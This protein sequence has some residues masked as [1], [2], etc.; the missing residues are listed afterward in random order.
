[1]EIRT[2]STMDDAAQKTRGPLSPCESEISVGCERGAPAASPMDLTEDESEAAPRSPSALDDE[3]TCLSEDEYFRPL[4]R[5][6]MSDAS[7]PPPPPSAATGAG[8]HASDSLSS[9]EPSSLAHRPPS[10]G[11]KQPQSPKAE[12]GDGDGDGDVDGDG[13]ADNESGRRA[14]DD[15]QGL[16][17]DQKLSGLRSFSILD[18]LSYKPS[19]RKSSIPVKIVRPWDESPTEAPPPSRPPAPPKR[20]G[21]QNSGRGS[22]LDALFKMT[23]KTLDNLNKEDKAGNKQISKTLLPNTPLIYF[24]FYYYY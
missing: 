20:E 22:A 14:A 1:M 11:A 7:P 13:D 21:G 19:R 24:L 16:A 3:S 6:A 8:G 10:E 15:R 17:A 2:P 4:K 12:E 5:L 23:N 9:P 18:I